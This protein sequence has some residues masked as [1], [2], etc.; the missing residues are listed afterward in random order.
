AGGDRVARVPPLVSALLIPDM[1]VAVWWVGDLPH[2]N[3]EYVDA[4]LEP[5]DRLIVDSC[6]FNDPA[7]L[8]IVARVAAKTL[9]APA[10][11]NWI[12][13]EEW[14]V[15]M[16]SMFDPPPMRT[17]LRDVRRIR[18]ITDAMQEHYFRE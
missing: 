14:R 4:L 17:K 5:A 9:T 12:R 15:A 10:D 7:D 18:I 8:E 6:Q 3:A 11:L 2:E 13:L 16:A 1:P